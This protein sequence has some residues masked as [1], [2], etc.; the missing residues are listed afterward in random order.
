MIRKNYYKRI[1]ESI[2]K[3]YHDNNLD[4]AMDSQEDNMGKKIVAII[5]ADPDQDL[6]WDHEYQPFGR[7]SLT[8]D[9]EDEAYAYEFG[10]DECEGEDCEHEGECEGD[11][12]DEPVIGSGFEDDDEDEF[13]YEDEDDAEG[14][15]SIKDVLMDI[16]DELSHLHAGD[17]D[18]A[19]FETSDENPMFGGSEE[20][21]D[22]W[23][24]D[25]E[26]DGEAALEAPESDWSDDEESEDDEWSDDEEYDE[27][28]D[29][30]EATHD[31]HQEQED[32]TDDEI[33]IFDCLD[34]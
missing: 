33:A 7:T 20:S 10:D 21:D 31:T 29:F 18:E 19:E 16:R 1:T 14:L 34:N 17:D 13:E 30:E 23:S 28:E 12:C 11:E 15:E 25:E 26:D 22:E 6:E 9:D 5:T 2:V 27:E 24:D 8:Q 32:S 4:S 3:A